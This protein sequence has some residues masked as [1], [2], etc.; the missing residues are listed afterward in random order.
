MVQAQGG[1]AERAGILV[2]TLVSFWLLGSFVQNAS[3]QDAAMCQLLQQSRQLAAEYVDVALER[4]ELDS[5][6]AG[7]SYCVGH[8]PGG[9]EGAVDWERATGMETAGYC[10]AFDEEACGGDAM[11]LE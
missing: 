9:W 8:F 3:V 7:S 5:S 1:A 4:S 2:K 11:E 6:C 10:T